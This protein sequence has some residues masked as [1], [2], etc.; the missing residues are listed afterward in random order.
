M[1]ELL[2]I[3]PQTIMTNT[4]LSGNVD[5]DKLLPIIKE[6]QLKTIEELLGSELYDKI[7]SDKE[8]GTL[9]GKYLILLDEYIK[10]ILINQTVASYILISPYTVGNGGFFKRSYNGVET[11]DNGEVDRVSQLYNSTAQMY[12]NRFN[13]WIVA[14]PLTEY[15][16][17]QDE[18]NAISSINLNNGWHFGDN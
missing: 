4:I 8:N 11:T 13:K 6:T 5:I 7:I 17:Y 9:A 15:K 1:P 10:P 12:V 18:V 16:T 3:E 2:L 14:N